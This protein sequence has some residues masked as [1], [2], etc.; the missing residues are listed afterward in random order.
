MQ[1]IGYKHVNNLL[2][3]E[4]NK[5][6]MLEYLVQDTRR[7]A[8]RQMTRFRKNQELN[9]FDRDDEE[10]ITEQVAEMLCL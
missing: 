4:W 1:A 2:A 9:W 7:Y 8:K 5:A 6:E 10:R 3:G